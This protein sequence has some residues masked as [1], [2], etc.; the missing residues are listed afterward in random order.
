MEPAAVGKTGV[1]QSRQTT[2]EQATG[3][4]PGPSS[5]LRGLENLDRNNFKIDDKKGLKAGEIEQRNFNLIKPIYINRQFAYNTKKKIADKFT[6]NKMKTRQ[7]KNIS[8]ICLASLQS[9]RKR[10]HSSKQNKKL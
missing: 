9:T 5:G 10:Q 3:L 2:G 1:E 4:A 7:S 8:K 6:L